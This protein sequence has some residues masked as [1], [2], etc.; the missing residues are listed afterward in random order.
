MAGVVSH[1]EPYIGDDGVMRFAVRLTP[2]DLADIQMGG[3]MFAASPDGKAH[4][5]QVRG[6]LDALPCGTIEINGEWKPL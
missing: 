4:A 5:E 3:E 2:E 1:E 6:V